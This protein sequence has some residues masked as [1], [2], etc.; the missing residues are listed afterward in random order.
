MPEWKTWTFGEPPEDDGNGRGDEGA[1]GNPTGPMPSEGLTPPAPPAKS[2]AEAAAERWSAEVAPFTL[3]R[4]AAVMEGDGFPLTREGFS[5]AT[6]ANGVAMRL[7]REPADAQWV[8]F[9]SHVPLPDG[10]DQ[11]AL[12]PFDLQQAANTWNTQHL[13]P[14][15]MPIRVDGIFVFHLSTRF[16]IGQGASERQIHLMITRGA[17]VTLQAAHDLPGLV[18]PPEDA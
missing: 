14:T 6:L 18:T 13:Q 2:P 15:V 7:H 1:P 9:E 17:V 11:S 16:F 8:Q 3:D 5:L 12:D 4:A 10:M